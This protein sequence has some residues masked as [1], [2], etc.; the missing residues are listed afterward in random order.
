M[1]VCIVLRPSLNYFP[2][3]AG[4]LVMDGG[5]D[6]GVSRKSTTSGKRTEK[7]PQTAQIEFEARQLKRH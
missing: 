4:Q 3:K 2:L 5:K 7:L 1:L 6:N